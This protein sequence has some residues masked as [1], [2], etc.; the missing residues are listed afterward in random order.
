MDKDFAYSIVDKAEFATLATTD[1]DGNPYC[2]PIS[3][4]R[5]GDI[6]YVHSAYKGAKIDNIK[7]NSCVCMSFVGDVN[8]PPPSSEEELARAME[9]PK[10]FGDYMSNKFTTEFESAIVFGNAHI[11]LDQAEKISGLR[12][13]AEKYAPHYMPHFH[14]AIEASLKVTCVLRIDIREITGKRKKYD[15]DGVEMKWGRMK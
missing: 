11:I 9:D 14:A 12:L 8:V 2:V 7:G 6:I 13:I 5:N 15:K 1:P 10:T 4:A 3:F